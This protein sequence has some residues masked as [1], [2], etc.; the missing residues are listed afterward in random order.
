[1]ASGSGVSSDGF[2][3][4]GSS[5]DDPVVGWSGTTSSGCTNLAD[6]DDGKTLDV[7][8]PGCLIDPRGVITNS[9]S[10]VVTA[11]VLF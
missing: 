2:S 6:L 8:P 1:M 4:V 10:K 3:S 7:R 5:A 9:F 11:K